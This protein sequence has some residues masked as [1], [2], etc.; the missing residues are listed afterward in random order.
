MKEFK[1]G[2]TIIHDQGKSHQY[3]YFLPE[4]INRDFKFGNNKVLTALEDATRLLGE[5][6]AYGT[7]V[8]DVDFFIQMHVTSEAVSSSKIEGTKTGMDEILLPA[9]EVPP[10]KRDDWQE[11]QNYISALNQGIDN[12]AELP[13]SVRLIKE[14]HQTLLSGVRGEH[15][16][17]GEI[18][19]SQNWIGGADINTAHFIPP[20]QSYLGELLTDWEKFWHNTGNNIPILIKVAICHYQFETI[21]PFLDGNGRI[22]RLLILLQL[23][24]RGHLNSPVLYLSHFFET[25]RQSYYDSLDRV[26]D[27]NDLEQWLL[28]FLT[29]V[30]ETS[31]QS[32]QTFEGIIRLQEIYNRKITTLGRRAERGQELLNH[33]FSNP[34]TSVKSVARHLGAQYS[35][36]NKLVSDLVTMGILK[37]ITGYSRNRYFAMS[38]YI[39][40]FR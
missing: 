2:Q 21:H 7:L 25:H 37:E 10:G 22:G 35:S 1:A 8:P 19:T 17:P 24:E 33:L 9:E 23:I 40:L 26:R 16:L 13:V 3:G 4:P 18:R 20:H 38:D 5:L 31:Q 15:K 14:T 30:I 28:F 29:G 27:H 11:V 6:S 12:L 34:V 32:K 36:T 39:K